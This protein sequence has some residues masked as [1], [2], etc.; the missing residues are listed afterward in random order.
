V[1]EARLLSVDLEHTG[2]PPAVVVRV[3]GELDYGT[4]P[5][6]LAAVGTVPASGV[7]LIL[8]LTGL[9]FCDSSALGVLVSLH[10]QTTAGGGR[11]YLASAG[12]QVLDAI[13]ITSLDQLLRVRD[14]VDAVR[15]EIEIGIS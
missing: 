5:C 1:D 8:D 6:L 10:K 13:T 2:P 11:L 4:T 12:P 7:D 15:H 3:D 14:S 9:K